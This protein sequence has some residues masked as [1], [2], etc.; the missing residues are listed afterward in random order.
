[1][2]EAVRRVGPG[3]YDDMAAADYHADPVSDPSL[4]SSIAK[5]LI[6][7]TP[8]H[9]WAA[10][11]RLNPT[12]APDDDSK[13]D[14][15]AAAHEMLLGRG[16]G[17]D[18]VDAA[19]WQTKGAREERARSRAAGRTPILTEQFDRATDMAR[20]VIERL[21][22]IPEAAELAERIPGL[23]GCCLANGVG[24]RVV[25]WR[26]IGGPLCR[27][28]L[29]FHGPSRADVWDLKTTGVGLSNEA[30]SRLIINLGYDLSAGFYLRG[31]AQ[32]FPEFAGRF[33]WRWIFVEDQAPFEVRV[34]EPNAELLA[35][36]D[37]KAAL[38]IEKWRRCLE[39]G[40]WPGYP[41]T[42]ARIV[43]PPWAFAKWNERELADD[44]AL[45]FRPTAAPIET[46]APKLVGPI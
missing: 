4:S 45:N 22:A 6:D 21:A 10:H 19:N 36:G 5:L 43:A 35:I 7:A 14:L 30:L 42:V 17:F 37:R 38:A 25:V 9:A 31:L 15:G 16:A 41:P 24:E 20:S 28:M 27:A 29:D 46:A 18:V 32:A 23:I 3:V 26:D 12:F 34:I 13:F 1:M 2:L 39:T 33:R 40:L 44:D 11:P 8:R